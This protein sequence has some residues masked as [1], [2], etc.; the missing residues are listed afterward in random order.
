MSLENELQRE[1]EAVEADLGRALARLEAEAAPRLLEAMRY[2]VLGGGKRLRG[3]LCRWICRAAGG[4]VNEAARE[5]ANALE[6]LHAYSLVHDDLPAMDD[7]DL[8][9]GRPS[10]HRAFDEATAILAGDTLQ[11]EAFGCLTRVLPAERG[12]G[13]VDLLSS[14]V[15]ARGMASGQQWDL[16][17]AGEDASGMERIH[18]YKTGRL[19]GAA[20]AMGALCGGV[21]DSRVERVRRAGEELGL[22]FQIVDDL[23]DLRSDS[24]TLGKTVG[25]DVAQGKLTAVRSLGEAGAEARA[26]NLLETSKRTLDEA[27]VLDARVSGLCDRL[28][29]RER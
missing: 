17:A 26:E 2:S 16:D 4:T 7:D 29:R 28:V 10:C 22:A 13:L 11:T 15:G 25:K 14:A 18:R 19:L 6:M 8:R 23:L 3:I 5:S 24:A 20:A 9:R 12:L 1:R 27:G 21:E